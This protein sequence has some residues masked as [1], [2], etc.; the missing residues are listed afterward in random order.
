MPMIIL[1]GNVNATDATSESDG[2]AS[3]IAALIAAG[4]EIYE[5][6]PA[7]TP[8]MVAPP[9]LSPVRAPRSTPAIP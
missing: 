6:L 2:F 3:G 5:A 9:T 1:N 4:A 8:S 7:N